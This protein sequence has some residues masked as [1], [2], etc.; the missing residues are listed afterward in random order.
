MA[1]LLCPRYLFY[2]CLPYWRCQEHLSP[3]VD[4]KV[5]EE[6]VRQPQADQPED[7]AWLDEVPREVSP[8]EVQGKA[9]EEVA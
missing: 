6:L 2:H 3:N 7:L 1:D 5:N 9:L 4:R 8:A